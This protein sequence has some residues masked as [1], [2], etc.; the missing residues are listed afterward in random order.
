MGK[1]ENGPGC[2]I[3]ERRITSSRNS[4][5]ARPI[6]N[7]YL[8]DLSKKYGGIPILDI[9]TFPVFIISKFAGRPFVLVMVS[10][11]QYIPNLYG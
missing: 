8:Y 5:K 3:L 9:L 2:I 10:C 4:C 1:N 6:H 7:Q 11:I